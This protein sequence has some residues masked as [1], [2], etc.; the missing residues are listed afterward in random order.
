MDAS[1]VRE[2]TGTTT[3]ACADLHINKCLPELPSPQSVTLR[4]EGPVIY[5]WP[6]EWQPNFTVTWMVSS[7][8]S[9]TI[10]LRGDT[11]PESKSI[12]G[13]C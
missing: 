11:V 4:F 2:E 5:L 10:E 3:R 6:S 13:R 9:I 7:T 8:C 1:H 12:H